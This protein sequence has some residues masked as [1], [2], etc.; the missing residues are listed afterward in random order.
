MA[1]MWEERVSFPWRKTIDL[2]RRILSPMGG[3]PREALRFNRELTNFVAVVPWVF[4][5]FEGHGARSR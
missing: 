4:A 5:V 3:N 2:F 1:P